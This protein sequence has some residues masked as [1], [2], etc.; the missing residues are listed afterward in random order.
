MMNQRARGCGY[1]LEMEWASEERNA[2]ELQA[3]QGNRS[4]EK[5]V[6]LDHG[7]YVKEG[8]EPEKARSQLRVLRR[9]QTPEEASTVYTSTPLL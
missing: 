7:L 2:E 6:D 8:C 3:S 4:Q 5:P 1:A 9:Q